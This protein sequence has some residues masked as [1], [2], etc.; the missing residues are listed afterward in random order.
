MATN[1]KVKIPQCEHC[2]NSAGNVLARDIQRQIDV[3]LTRPEGMTPEETAV[4][5]RMLGAIER[6]L[7]GWSD[8]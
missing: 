4:I 6:Y 2:F 7:K 5:V 1:L 8:K 3:S